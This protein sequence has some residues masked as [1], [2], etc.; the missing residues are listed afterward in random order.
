MFWSSRS[1]AVV[2]FV[3]LD[4]RADCDVSS[5]CLIEFSVFGSL[6]MGFT[7]GY[8]MNVFADLIDFGL[9]VLK[10]NP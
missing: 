3:A 2:A 7:V 5:Y 10:S 6:L 1:E 9:I 4:T 8:I